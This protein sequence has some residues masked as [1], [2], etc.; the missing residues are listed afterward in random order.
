MA[1]ATFF[2]QDP[3]VIAAVENVRKC[4]DREFS[5]IVDDAGHQYVD[6]VME[7]GGV[8]GIALVGYTY[9]L[10]QAGIRFLGVGGTSAGSINALMIAALA[11]PE[12]AK[13]KEL[14]QILANMPMDSFIDGDSDARHFS[15]AVIKK[16]GMMKLLWKAAQVMDNLKE[17]LGLNPGN[18][19]VEWLTGELVNKGIR[20]SADLQRNLA[21]VPAGLHIRGGVR[22]D[23]PLA[24][25]E[26]VGRLAMIAADITTETKAEFP[27]M[28]ELYWD[29]PDKVNPACFARA[30]MSIPFFFHPF[31]VHGCPQ[32]QGAAWEKHAGYCG[33]LPT[34]VM[35][36]DGGIMSNFPINIFHEPYRVP[37]APTFGAKIG[38]DRDKPAQITK[39]AQLL[40]AIFDVA[41]HT[42]DDDFI[43]QNPDYRHLVTMIDT[44]DHNWLNFTMADGDKLN[45]FI[46]GAEAAS[47]FLCGFDWKQYKEIRKGIADAFQKSR[48]GGE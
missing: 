40:G 12:V 9:V 42:L 13:S 16:V 30:S 47:A 18:A 48:N 35:F 8:L 17:D 5:D 6:L 22:V 14:V 21:A 36:M 29:Q 1:D 25:E 44:G 39:P 20:T 26:K 38:A 27:K 10:E 37:L 33:T 2:T 3:R 32:N 15:G 24:V 4:A 45:L 19:F 28:A 11:K 41:R 43:A 7:G 34:E 46:R 31:R 23:A